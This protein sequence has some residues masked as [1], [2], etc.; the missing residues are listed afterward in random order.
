MKTTY[1]TTDRSQ[2]A[3]MATKAKAALGE[4][5]ADEETAEAAGGDATAKGDRGTSL[6]HDQALHGCDALRHETTAECSGRDESS[7]ARL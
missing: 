3:S 1:A 5:T 2:L 4:E 6:C 7:C